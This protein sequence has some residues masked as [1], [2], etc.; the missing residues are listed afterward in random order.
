MILL[1]LLGVLFASTFIIHSNID[2]RTLSIMAQ[3][4]N[5]EKNDIFDNLL[6]LASK[7]IETFAFDYTY[8]D[9]MVDFVKD[10]QNRREWAVQNI[11]PGLSVFNASSAW[12][13]DLSGSLVYSVSNLKDEALKKFP[14]ST[15]GIKEVFAE[16]RLRHFFVNTGQ[17]V[18][19]VRGST[20]HPTT[21]PERKT[22]PAGYFFTARLWDK[23]YLAELSRLIGG[24]ITVVPFSQAAAAADN[25]KLQL[26]EIRL[27]R[28]LKGP[29][30][31][32]V[33]R[34]N[35]SSRSKSVV[36]LQKQIKQYFFL[37]AFFAFV[38]FALVIIFVTR[39]ISAP[40]NLISKA[41]RGQEP[42]YIKA[43]YKVRN[44]FGEISR[45]I[46]RFVEQKESLARQ[47]SDRERIEAALKE[48]EERF[49]QV[50]ENAS[51]WVW[52]INQEGLYVYSNPA[53]KDVMGYEPDE[54]VG[55]KYFY[56]FFHPDVREELKNKA[57]AVL[58]KKEIFRNF[59]NINVH[60]NGN[61]VILETNGSPAI[62]INGNFKGYRGADN[63]ITDSRRAEEELRAAYDQLKETQ[64][65]LVQSAKMASV[66]QLAGSIAHEINNPLTGVLNNIQLVKLMDQQ[67]KDLGIPEIRD[68]L[69]AIEES[70]LRC[71]NITQSLL[72]FSRAAKGTM[73]P[74]SLNE[75]V[76]RVASIIEYEM[77]LQNISIRKELDA[78]LPLVSGNFQLLQQVIFD[79]IVNAKWAIER[80]AGQAG[81]T[82]IIKSGLD[83][84]AK[85]AYIAISDTGIGISAENLSKVFNPFFTT[86]PEGE[87]TGLG[88]SIASGIIREHRGKI[89]VESEEG[90]GATFRIKL[91]FPGDSRSA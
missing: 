32:P 85:Q 42:A 15:E 91:P 22:D 50:T 71:K 83:A 8:W 17:G 24:S 57:F 55:K 69:D 6:S 47:I 19:E 36:L 7:G 3:Q 90:K 56:D 49:R 81:G 78:D 84:A 77:K 76:E 53:V 68:I 73:Q 23:G 41:L 33:A 66:G 28:I 39:W 65:Q 25:A 5:Q 16:K 74:I 75:I 40:L 64:N 21:D 31:E 29:Y 27:S 37:F 1:L 60:K 88:L 35:A 18:E 62:D 43:F 44:E 59:I 38:V 20:I 86:K 48:S 45:L 11:D 63:D 26:G 46:Q 67:K 52:E 79:M 10:P 72:N 58:A 12:I 61:I 80:K 87:G 70:A 14:L 30:D 34:L 13:F 51:V 82:I 4:A 54:I 2:R 89:E 9:E